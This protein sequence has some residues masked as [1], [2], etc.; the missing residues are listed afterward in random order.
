MFE[1]RCLVC[2]NHLLDDG[3][4]YC[5]DICENNDMSSPCTSSSSSALA[6]PQLSYAVG[7]EVPALV[8][9]V[10]GLALGKGLTGKH[11]YYAS[12][13]SAS[14]TSWSAITDDE[15]AEPHSD[16]LETPFDAHFTSHGNLSALSYARRPSGTNTRFTVPQVK[17]RSQSPIRPHGFPRSAPDHN[18]FTLGRQELH[19]DET[20]SSSDTLDSD[21]REYD[22]HSEKDKRSSTSK[23]KRSRNRASLPACFS[24][25]QMA[26]PSNSHKSSPISSS[27]GITIAACSSPPT[28]KLLHKATPSAV[29]TLSCFPRQSREAEQP[30]HSRGSSEFSSP[31]TKITR[32][33][34]HK[35]DE[36]STLVYVRPRGRPSTRRNSSP[37][38]KM[39]AEVGDAGAD[40]RRIPIHSDQSETRSRA[41]TRGRMRVED[42]DGIG[43]SAIAPGYG[44]GRSGLVNRERFQNQRIHL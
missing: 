29:S 14:S 17:Q 20:L 1:E 39:V 2:G 24:L 10:L 15:D 8:P 7:G 35:D 18:R 41:L 11:P 12:S 34:S 33:C 16:T 21:E 44:N 4:A 31:R 13:S 6:S 42:L 38:P 23:V 25:L 36:N 5:S 27:S 28:P 37:L 3:R 30:L 26:S 43:S 40:V 32:A 19:S 22:I 9:S